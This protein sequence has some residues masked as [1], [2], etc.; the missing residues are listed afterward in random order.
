MKYCEP[1]PISRTEAEMK[2]ATGLQRE[3]CTALV[4]ITYNES[5]WRWAQDWCLH[6]A[7]HADSGVRGVAAN[8]LGDL[9]RIHG[10]LELEKVFPV[11]RKLLADPEVVGRAEDA[12]DDIRIF[13]GKTL[14]K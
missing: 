11:L 9:A 3:I 8:C 2:F 6:F 12:L 14:D 4:R 1:D 10:C 7:E 5:D 13:M